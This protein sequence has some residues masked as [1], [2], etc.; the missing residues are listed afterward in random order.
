MPDSRPHDVHQ[1]EAVNCPR[2]G[3]C[4][5]E[6]WGGTNRC[7][8]CGLNYDI[9]TT[10]SRAQSGV[11]G[12][13][14]GPE[15][16]NCSVAQRTKGSRGVRQMPRATPSVLGLSPRQSDVEGIYHQSGSTNGSEYTAYTGRDAEVHLAMRELSPEGTLASSD[17]LEPIDAATGASQERRLWCWWWSDIPQTE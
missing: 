12:T 10:L 13:S 9:T 7:G 2:C 17:A 3:L 1:V 5:P 14:E 6:P 16:E 11:H 4:R 15:A 8:C